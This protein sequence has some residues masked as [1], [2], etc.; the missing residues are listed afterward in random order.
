MKQ[1]WMER[2]SSRDDIVKWVDKRDQRYWEAVRRVMEETRRTNGPVIANKSD[3]NR[4][5][6]RS[7]TSDPTAMKRQAPDEW[8][9]ASKESKRYQK[10]DLEM[11]CP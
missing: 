1:W 9:A 5:G 3:I 7:S 11:Y 6:T 10:R 4:W 8:A 2:G